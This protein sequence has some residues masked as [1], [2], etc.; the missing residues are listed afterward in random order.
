MKSFNLP[1]IHTKVQ[2]GLSTVTNNIFI[3]TSRFKNFV[4]SPIVSGLLDHD[5]QLLLIM[6]LNA[7]IK[8]NKGMR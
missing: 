3:D 1:H 4:I 8:S 5:G 6:N 7:Y 2:N